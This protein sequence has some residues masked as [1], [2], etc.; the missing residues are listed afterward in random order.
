[1]FIQGQVLYF[2]FKDVVALE[3]IFIYQLFLI[4]LQIIQA[5][6][7]MLLINEELIRGLFISTTMVKLK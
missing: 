5:A 2:I 7:E 4:S 3:N 1:M 6:T